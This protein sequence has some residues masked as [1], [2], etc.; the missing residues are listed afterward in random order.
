MTA[1]S[2]ADVPQT[3][4]PN[5][6]IWALTGAAGGA[7]ALI[8]TTITTLAADPLPILEWL[9]VGAVA[10]IG[11]WLAVYDFREHRLP[12]RLVWP[13]YAVTGVLVGSCGIV[14]GDLGRV[15]VALLAGAALWAIYFVLGL[16]GAVAFGDVK[17][18]GALGLA[19]GWWG[20]VP[21][22]L[23]AAAAYVLALPHAVAH[24]AGRRGRQIPFGPYMVAGTVAVALW[25]ILTTS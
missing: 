25:Q 5:P 17:L 13:L 10:A 23:G 11:A 8:A 6:A 2:P 21:A 18:A 3:R 1:T 7:T 16:L 4:N 12:N 9:L 15:G 20:I 14:S 22:L 24:A 19:L